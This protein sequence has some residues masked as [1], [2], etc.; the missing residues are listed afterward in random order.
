MKKKTVLIDADLRRPSVAGILGL[1][2]TA[3]A[4]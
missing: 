4:C 1:Q 3:G 2:G